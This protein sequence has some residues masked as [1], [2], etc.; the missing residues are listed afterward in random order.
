MAVD[1]ER[2]DPSRTL[3]IIDEDGPTNGKLNILAYFS[4]AIS[5]IHVSN[6]VPRK[7]KDR[8]NYGPRDQR[9][10]CFLIGQMAKNDA[11]QEQI[12]G[13]EILDIEVGFLFEARQKVAGAAL[14]LTARNMKSY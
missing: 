8:L 11:C 13:P 12:T 4:L 3:L 14:E 6:E 9:S 7:V 10:P 1:F 5:H 2:R